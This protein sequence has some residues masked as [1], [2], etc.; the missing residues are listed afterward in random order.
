MIGLDASYAPLVSAKE[1]TNIQDILERICEHIPAPD[2]D[3][4]AP[5]KALIFDSYYDNYKGV[6]LFVRVKDGCV[7]WAIPSKR[8]AATRCST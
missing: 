1:G 4:E 7:K 8:S 3:T 2:G 5:L 6:I